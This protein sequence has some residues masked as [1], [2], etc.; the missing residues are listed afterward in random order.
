MTAEYEVFALK[1][2]RRDAKRSDHF[3]GGDP[4]DAPMPMDYYIWVIRNADRTVVVDSGFTA[5]V[6]AKRKREHLRC[7]V[8]SLKLL[9]IDP[10]T[11]SDVVL[12]H[13]H[14][15]HVGN[16]HKFAKAH[17]HLQTREMGFVTG[18]YMRYPKF[19][20]SFEVEDVV[21]MV[22]L[23]FKGR[24]EQHKEDF[25]LADGI[26]LHHVGGHTPGLQIVRVMTK[27]GWVVLASDA[28]H[29]YEHMRENKFFIAAFNLG[30]MVDAYRTAERLAASKDHVVPGHDPLVME[31]YPAASKELEGIVVRLDVA[32]NRSV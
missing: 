14:Y 18:P 26:T 6:A 19:G 8:D 11:V 28:A 15:D 22:K 3:I 27:R 5:E 7:P 31:I 9:N 25:E 20:H 21:G 12:T 16:F 1:Y 32:P 29:Y 24:V 23:N 13:L 30:D 17:F 4:H 2:A 10:D